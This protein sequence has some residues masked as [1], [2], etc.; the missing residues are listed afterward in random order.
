[1]TTTCRVKKRVR[2]TRKPKSCP[3]PLFEKWLIELKEDAARKDSKLQYVYGKALKSLQKYPLVLESAKECKVLQHFGDGLCKI[4][5]KKLTEHI[6]HGG[7][8]KNN[9]ESDSS[10]DENPPSKQS[11]PSISQRNPNTQP[12]EYIPTRRSGAYALLMALH[13]HATVDGYLK[14]KDLQELAQPY[15]DVSFC[16][17]DVVNAQYYSA[18]SS[19]TTLI[20][21][22]LVDKKGNP[23]KYQL[24]ESGKSL[25]SRLDQAEADLYC[26]SASTAFHRE[27][28]EK[29]PAKQVT[30]VKAASKGDVKAPRVRKAIAQTARPTT[31]RGIDTP[32]TSNGILQPDDLIV[33]DDDEFDRYA[34]QRLFSNSNKRD[35]AANP[36]EPAIQEEEIVVEEQP[37]PYT[38]IHDKVT[39]K[40]GE[41]DIVLCVDIA[42]VS[43][44]SGSGKNQ[45]E[46]ASKS[47]QNCGVPYDVRKLSIGDYLWIC[48]PK[49]SS[50]ISSDQELALPYVVERKRMDDVV[51]SIKDGRFKEQKFRLKHSGLVRPIYLIEE[52]GNRQNLGMPEASVLQAIAN[53]LIIEK[54]QVQWTQKSDDSVAFLVQMTKQLTEIYHGKTVTS[55]GCQDK[56]LSVTQMFAKQLMQLHGLSG[57]KAEAI[58]KVYPTPSSLMD[59]LKSAG[60]SASTLL[61]CLEYGK[62]K[63][64]IG[65]SISA[66]LAKLYTEEHLR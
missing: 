24:T 52:F 4:I 23:A 45:K 53:T 31:L 14:K 41:Y 56:P 34:Q 5:E 22:E 66:L 57:E 49:T 27:C 21:K 47:F 40:A 2:I 28:G 39:L 17:T 60:A 6:S 33:I 48:K 58:V 15:A 1:M 12:K 8:L 19:M 16:Q 32:S 54:F 43:G 37:V 55:R 65:L 42:E 51:S 10:E 25:A 59:A 9:S 26:S 3:N 18:W 46:T 7:S 29:F 61:S 20:N 50:G 63:R 35:V 44:S 36:V 30:P 11:R 64:K 38:H 13:K 62:A